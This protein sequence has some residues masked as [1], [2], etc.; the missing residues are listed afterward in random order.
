MLLYVNKKEI[1]RKKIKIFLIILFS[2]LFCY[3][4]IIH[5]KKNL[6][7]S[8]DKISSYQTI[9]KKPIHPFNI[10]TVEIF[11]SKNKNIK[12]ILLPQN[13][14]K[15]TTYKIVKALNIHNN[16]TTVYLTPEIKNNILLHQIINYTK[17]EISEVITPNTTILTTNIK[18]LKPLIYKD[19]LYPKSI[20]YSYIDD[21]TLTN[22]INNFFKKD[23]VAKN[24][25]EE[26]QHNLQIFIKDNKKELIDLIKNKSITDI[27]YPKQNN[28]LKNASFCIKTSQQ[29]ICN[30]QKNISFVKSISQT[31]K[32]IPA[33]EKIQKL[34]LL[35][36]FEPIDNITN[37]KN[38]GLLFKYEKRQ[39]ILLPDEITP[40]SFD[41]IKIKSGINPTFKTNTMHY[42]QFRT[43][44]IEINDNI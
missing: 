41:D 38:S 4:N 11:L 2:V 19:K 10:P 21:I 26:E 27:Y 31:L 9:T 37:L 29:T 14:T 35:T 18:D 44:E 25:L 40:T 22:I 17:H 3:A 7:T 28:L 12:H 24:T 8:P 36:S 1:R 32:T 15:E 34:I 39:A 42:Y 43:V 6:H 30:T 5:F 33:N 20:T 13:I 16:T 23:F